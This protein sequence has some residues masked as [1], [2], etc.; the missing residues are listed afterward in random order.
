MSSSQLTVLY[1]NMWLHVSTNYMVIMTPLVHI[2]PKLQ[3]QISFLVS[4]GKKLTTIIIL[5]LCQN[6]V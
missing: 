3:L 2:K 5:E 6:P 4:G 1:H